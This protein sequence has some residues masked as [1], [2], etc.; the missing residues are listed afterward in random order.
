[1]GYLEGRECG[2]I[3]RADCMAAAE[4]ASCVFAAV[5]SGGLMGAVPELQP[6]LSSQCV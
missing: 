2:G 4:I 6:A 3:S 5:L 1:M